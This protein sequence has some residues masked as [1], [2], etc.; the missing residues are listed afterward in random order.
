MPIKLTWKETIRFCGMRKDSPLAQHLS[1]KAKSQAKLTQKEI[2]AI[3]GFAQS[4]VGITGNTNKC[5]K[6]DV[7]KITGVP[8]PPELLL[9]GER[10]TVTSRNGWLVDAETSTVLGRVGPGCDTVTLYPNHLVLVNDLARLLTSHV[11]P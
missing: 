8:V 7:A 10:A 3:E 5:V 9:T 4:F 2:D 11:T 6:V 1:K